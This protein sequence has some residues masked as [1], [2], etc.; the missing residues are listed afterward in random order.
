MTGEQPFPQELLD[1]A[2]RMRDAV[3]LHVV[4]AALGVRDRN[5]CWVAIKLEDGRSDGN[6]YESRQDAVN[7]TQNLSRGWAY[8]KVGADSM[9]ERESL[10]VLQTFRMAFARGVIFAEE[11]VVVPH[12]SELMKPFLPATMRKLGTA[13]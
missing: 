2:A 4:A 1:A 3:N 6:L 9:G 7:H 12:L 5:L 10:I 13:R 11:E 8:L